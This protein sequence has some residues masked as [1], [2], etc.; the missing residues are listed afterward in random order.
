[1]LFCYLTFDLSTIANVIS[2]LT[3]LVLVWY[4]FYS[5]QDKIVGQYFQEIKGIYSGIQHKGLDEHGY[6][7]NMGIVLSIKKASKHLVLGEM[8]YLEKWSRNG[9]EKFKSAGIIGIYGKFE[10]GLLFD[11]FYTSPVG[12]ENLI[13]KGELILCHPFN[14]DIINFNSQEN[15]IGKYNVN[16]YVNPNILEFHLNEKGPCWDEK[17]HTNKIVVI[18][19]SNFFLDKTEYIVSE[20]LKG[21]SRLFNEHFN[22]NNS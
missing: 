5:K 4:Y 15:I 7:V 2:I 9:E 1:M 20:Y 16:H 10:P 21:K 17:I 8:E 11:G 19:K 6:Y 13:V 14:L 18:Q 12:S 3:A 22:T